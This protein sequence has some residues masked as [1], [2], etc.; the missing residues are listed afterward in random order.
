MTYSL[1]IKPEAERDL[2]QAFLFYEEQRMGLGLEFL[3]TVDA[4]MNSVKRNPQHFQ[5]KHLEI[6]RAFTNRFPYGIFFFIEGS[7]VI[8]LA[9]ISTKMDETTWM[10]RQSI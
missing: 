10:N 4:L 6:R 9:I 1:L 5:K 7:V 3:F 8:V 2:Q